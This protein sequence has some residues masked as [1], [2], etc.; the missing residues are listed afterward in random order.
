MVKKVSKL[1]RKL[2]RV[3]SDKT[4]PKS[5]RCMNWHVKFPIFT[6]KVA[7]ACL[8]LMAVTNPL[9]CAQGY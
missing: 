7:I 2:I 9:I 5:I 3:I 6:Q 8:Y 1:F 4:V